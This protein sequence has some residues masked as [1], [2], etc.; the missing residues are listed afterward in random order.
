[1]GHFSS[2][3]SKL[4]ALAGFKTAYSYYHLNGGR[5]VFPFT[6]V[7]YLKIERGGSLPTPRALTVLLDN[8]RRGHAPAERRRLV[9]D[10]LRDLAGD[11]AIYDRLFAPLSIPTA[12]SAQTLAVRNLRAHF[13]I[14]V[15]IPQLRAIAASQEATG[16][17]TLL[18]GIPNSL[19]LKEISGMLGADEKQCLTALRALRGRRLV[20]STGKD[21]WQSRGS[22]MHYQLPKSEAASDLLAKMNDHRRALAGKRGPEYFS[23]QLTLRLDISALQNAVAEFERVYAS[24]LASNQELAA[25]GPETPVCMIETRVW[26]MLTFGGS[27]GPSR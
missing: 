7:H 14:Q 22:G 19:T 23:N 18:A 25:P 12:E 4:R 17:F 27:P 11:A 8:L 16:A 15:T 6:Y 10:Y 24:I 21:S 3:F 9:E 26:R 1:M 13:S 20:R 5:G 2:S